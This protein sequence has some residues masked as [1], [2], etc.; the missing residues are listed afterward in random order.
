MERQQSSL[1]LLASKPHLRTS[2]H[3]RPKH[4]RAH[5]SPKPLDSIHAT[6]GSLIDARER[7]EGIG[8]RR[9]PRRARRLH[10]HLDQVARRRYERADGARRHAREKL[11]AECVYARDWGPEEL[12][13]LK[14][15]GARRERE[16]GK[17]TNLEVVVAPHPDGS[18]ACFS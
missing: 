16:R 6:T 7:S 17:E 10:L 3:G 14:S 12:C 2:K 8:V 5:A 11:R 13:M 4:R 15:V 1:G 9:A 18:V